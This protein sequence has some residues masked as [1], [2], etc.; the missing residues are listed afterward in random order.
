MKD[1]SL[2]AK[3]KRFARRVM[4]R[5]KR[6]R[7]ELYF[8]RRGVRDNIPHIEGDCPSL[9][10]RGTISFGKNCA[11]WSSSRD[12]TVLYV[13]EGGRLIIGEGVYIN[14]G[15]LIHVETG[16]EVVIE[17][18][19]KLGNESVLFTS[20][21]HPVFPGAPVKKGNIRLKRNCWIGFRAFVRHG[22]T[23]G[24]N[25]IVGA[26]A[27]AVKDVPDNAIA[28]GNPAKVVSEIIP[29]PAPGWIRP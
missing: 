19:A 11:I 20:D 18:H 24:E 16:C 7:N 17:S 25:S 26:M 14:Q 29:A 22:V 10:N 3:G 23:V 15:A 13:N 28:G 9:C 5:C 2:F 8:R 6:F 4:K 12:R 27:L 21:Y 1:D